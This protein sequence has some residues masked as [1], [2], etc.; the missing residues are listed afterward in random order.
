MA[1]NTGEVMIREWRQ[2]GG[3]FFTAKL[4]HIVHHTT[5]TCETF[6]FLLEWQSTFRM[7]TQDRHRSVKLAVLGIPKPRSASRHK[8]GGWA[9]KGFRVQGVSGRTLEL[10][11][12][13]GFGI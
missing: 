12:R 7:E 8:I 10:G 9:G 13:R 3:R 4:K 1:W 5:V 11:P 6:R 2:L